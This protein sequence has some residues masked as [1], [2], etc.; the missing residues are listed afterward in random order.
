MTREDFN[1]KY[2]AFIER[3]SYDNKF[4]QPVVQKFEGLEFDVPEV[5][6]FLD[7]VFIDLTR[8]PG[9][10]YSQIKLKFGRARFYSTAPSKLNYE[11]ETDIDNLI[12]KLE[13]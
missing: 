2:D 5:T 9:F 1:I 13:A 4:G 10:T 3:R 7:K 6:E 8:I 11:I 12:K